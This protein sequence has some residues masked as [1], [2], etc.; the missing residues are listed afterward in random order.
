MWFTTYS[1]SFSA[2][3]LLWLMSN[4][5]VRLECISEGVLRHV[6]LASF[7]LRGLKSCS[8]KAD[9]MAFSLRMK[10]EENETGSPVFKKPL[11][12]GIL[13]CESQRRLLSLSCHT[14]TEFLLC[15]QP[16]LHS[17]VCWHWPR[18]ETE[19]GGTLDSLFQRKEIQTVLWEAASS[20]TWTVISLGSS[21]FTQVN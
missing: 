17:P 21:V 4:T 13:S 3:C 1:P 20:W 11:R 10:G 18:G 8:E 12:S 9:S 15:A 7:H 2:S 16:Q 19:G 6:S 14:L 5:R